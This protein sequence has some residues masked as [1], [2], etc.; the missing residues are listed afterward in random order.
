MVWIRFGR[1]KRIKLEVHSSTVSIHKGR[2]TRGEWVKATSANTSRQGLVSR[3]L[4]E[5]IWVCPFTPLLRLLTTAL[6]HRLVH[7]VEGFH[8]VGMRV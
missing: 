1:T 7:L 2:V 5:W 3:L 4:P 6:D 8:R